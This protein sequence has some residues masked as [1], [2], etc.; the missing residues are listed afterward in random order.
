MPRNCKFLS[1]VVC[2]KRPDLVLPSRRGWQTRGA[3]A[4]SSHARFSEIFCVFFLESGVFYWVAKQPGCCSQRKPPGLIKHVLTVLV[5]W[6][7]V[8]VPPHLPNII[9]EPQIVRLNKQLLSWPFEQI[10]G[11]ATPSFPTTRAKKGCR[12]QV[13]AP[14]GGKHRY[15]SLS[16]PSGPKKCPGSFPRTPPPPRFRGHSR[17]EHSR[18]TCPN[19]RVLAVFLRWIQEGFS[20]EPPRNDSE[21][22]FQ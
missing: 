11:S 2:R 18:D 6:S 21:A 19:F 14:Q 7:Q 9:Q 13:F 1:P 20:V 4:V 8:L 10:L 5:F 22:N 12:A 15:R 16:G 17:R 3:G